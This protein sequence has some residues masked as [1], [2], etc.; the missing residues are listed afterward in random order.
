MQWNL[1]GQRV[2]GVYLGAYTV[3]GTVAWSRVKYGGTVQHTVV[4]DK[5]LALFGTE[6]ESVLLDHNELLQGA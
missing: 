1:E 3:T 6:R 4:L 5:P 2:A